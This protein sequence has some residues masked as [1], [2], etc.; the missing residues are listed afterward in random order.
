M[1]PDS[2]APKSRR[3]ALHG[4]DAKA[5]LGAGLEQGPEPAKSTE[6]QSPKKISR[7]NLMFGALAAG[8]VI[9]AGALLYP[10]KTKGDWEDLLAS[11]EPDKTLHRGDWRKDAGA[12]E[13]THEAQAAMIQLPLE[14][15]GTN[16]D[17]RYEFTRVS[18]TKSVALFFATAHGIGSLE[19]DSW[20]QP[21]LSGVQ[22]FDGKDLRLQDSFGFGLENGQ[23]YEF[24]LQVRTDKI[25][26][27]HQDKELRS[28]SLAGRTLEVI[29]PW[30]WTNE[31]SSTQLALGTWKSPTRFSKLELKRL[32]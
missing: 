1:T 9:A 22:M 5:L 6:P 19:F 10:K 3:P 32:A 18:G 21:G 13:S 27:S 8:G 30:N 25:T 11:I 4:L 24:L 20:E 12:L 15:L 7:R 31:W 14:K 23:A 28:Y 16:Y 2:R 26:V 17:L 29:S